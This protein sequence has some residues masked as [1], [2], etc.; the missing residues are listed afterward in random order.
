MT[1]QTLN[2][3]FCCIS[4]TLERSHCNIWKKRAARFFSWWVLCGKWNF[5]MSGGPLFEYK[6]E[7]REAGREGETQTNFSI[8]NIRDLVTQGWI[9][10]QHI[11]NAAFLNFVYVCEIWPQEEDATSRSWGPC[12]IKIYYFCYLSK[13]VNF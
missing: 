4:F 13:Y 2:W 1:R 7:E 11:H 8:E 3:I 9:N 5:F 6:G 12:S 10:T